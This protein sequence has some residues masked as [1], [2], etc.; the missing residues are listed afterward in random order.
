M[1]IFE[2]FSWGLQILVVQ[3]SDKKD[4]DFAG[5]VRELEVSG[6]R[7]YELKGLKPAP[8]ERFRV[9]LEALLT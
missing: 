5:E 3:G 6:L 8:R 7:I 1:R 9:Y 2:E 4:S